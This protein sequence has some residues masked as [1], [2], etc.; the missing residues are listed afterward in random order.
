MSGRTFVCSI[1][2][3]EFERALLE[4]HHPAGRANVPEV[5]LRTCPGCHD[6]LGEQLRAGGVE[7]NHARQPTRGEISWAILRGLTDVFATWA[8]RY[9][10][11][12]EAASVGR[13]AAIALGR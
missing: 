6:L 9:P 4:E 10:V 3:H 5:T 11:G 7:L 1:C 8:S 12:A 2:G 13:L